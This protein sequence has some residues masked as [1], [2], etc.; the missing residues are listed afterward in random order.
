MDAAEEL[1]MT[2]GYNGFSYQD[3]APR[4]GIKTASIHYHFP[5][6]QMLG[7]KVAQRYAERHSDVLEALDAS[8]LSAAAKL[9]RYLVGFHGVV[10]SGPRV[11]L[12]AAV[13]AE[14]DTVGEALRGEIDSFFA[15]HEEWL[16]RNLEEGRRAGDIAFAGTAGDRATVMFSALEGALIVS[17]GRNDLETFRRVI[18]SLRADLSV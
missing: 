15:F 2:R 5:K 14:F 18:A 1:I 17:R 9:D 16:E 4:L 10:G 11:C 6:K 8:Y 12:C 7:V 13:A 3:I